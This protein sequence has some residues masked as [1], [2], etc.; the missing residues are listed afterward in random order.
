[1]ATMIEGMKKGTEVTVIHAFDTGDYQVIRAM[2]KAPPLLLDFAF[3]FHRGEVEGFTV[4]SFNTEWR[5]DNKA[6]V[7]HDAFTRDASGGP[8]GNATERTEWETIQRVGG[9]LMN[10]PSTVSRSELIELLTLI[11]TEDLEKLCLDELR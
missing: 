9:A 7:N 4:S 3:T 6:L 2:T 10:A 1:M 8:P 11:S 5:L